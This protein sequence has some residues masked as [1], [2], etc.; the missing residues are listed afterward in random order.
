MPTV[1]LTDLL[2]RLDAYEAFVLAQIRRGAGAAASEAEAAMHSTQAHG[3]VTGATRAAYRAYV[4]SPGQ[5]GASAIAEAVEAA[6]AKNPGRS[7]TSSGTLAGDVGVIFTCP[8]DY[9][10]NL[11]EEGAGKRAVLGPTL[12]A[13]RDELTARAAKGA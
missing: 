7:A 10:R 9:Q 11:E 6:E 4:V 1:D 12:D 3:D 5:S 8:T 13:F 2:A